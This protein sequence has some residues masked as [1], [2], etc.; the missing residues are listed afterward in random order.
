MH[1]STGGAGNGAAATTPAPHPTDLTMFR[2]PGQVMSV[3]PMIDG[4]S[5]CVLSTTL[6][7]QLPWENS[8]ATGTQSRFNGPE[9]RCMP[10]L[11]RVIEGKVKAVCRS[12]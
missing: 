5:K 3:G 6:K 2:T 10:C 1:G 4:L 9:H 12:S 11:A 7:E 8:S